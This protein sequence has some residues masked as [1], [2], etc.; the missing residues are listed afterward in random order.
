MRLAPQLL[1]KNKNKTPYI[2]RDLE[3]TPATLGSYLKEPFVGA[4]LWL[5]MNRKNIVLSQI[6]LE[7]WVSRTVLTV[8]F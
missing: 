3:T 7:A 6:I 8:G 2:C 1:P 5:L 4:C